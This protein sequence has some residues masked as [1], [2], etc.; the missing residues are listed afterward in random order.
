MSETTKI[1]LL[2]ADVLLR[3]R[4]AQKDLGM[5]DAHKEADDALCDLLTALGYEN[6]VNEYRKIDKWFA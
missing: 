2:E 5:E 1:A 3:L 6:V 4:D